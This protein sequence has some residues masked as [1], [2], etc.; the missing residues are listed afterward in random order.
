L[1]KP[2]VARLTTF[3]VRRLRIRP[4][5]INC[6]APW[7]GPDTTCSPVGSSNGYHHEVIFKV[8]GKSRA[9][10]RTS[11]STLAINRPQESRTCVLLTYNGVRKRGL[12]HLNR[13][14][15]SERG[16]AAEFRG[17]AL[18]FHPAA[19]WLLLW[20][21][22]SHVVDCVTSYAQPA[23]Q[24]PPDNVNTQDCVQRSAPTTI[25]RGRAP[26]VRFIG[27]H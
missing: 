12:R 24:A 17:G 2:T 6:D 21:P 22:K 16:T 26:N 20:G 8:S 3:P 23:T 13:G 27:T 11:K 14:G 18:R 7:C 4:C 10:T 5:C 19:R 15:A 1:R 25:R 9:Y